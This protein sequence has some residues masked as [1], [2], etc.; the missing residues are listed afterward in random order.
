[1]AV[2]L[3][4]EMTR[5]LALL[6]AAMAALG[7]VLFVLASWS[8]ASAQKAQRLRILELSEKTEKL[9]TDL[10]RQVEASGALAALQ[11]QV[12]TTREELGRVTQTRADVQ[13]DLLAAQRSL[14][15]AKREL[16]EADRNLQSN[17]VASDGPNPSDVT[18]ATPDV[19]PEVRAGR[20]SGR[21]TYR[22]S[23]RSYSVR[24]R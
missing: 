10:A 2:D 23:R 7:W 4:A 22:R 12:A 6:L 5:P 17:R 1:M 11:A 24:S 8:S 16:S 9:S 3:K 21:R 18:A 20:R 13:T 14:A 15:G 19:E